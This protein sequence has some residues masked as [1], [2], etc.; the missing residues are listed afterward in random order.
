[1]A[2]NQKIL[3]LRKKH[4]FQGAEAEGLTRLSGKSRDVVKAMIAAGTIQYLDEHGE[5]LSIPVAELLHEI[6][7][8]SLCYTPANA[9]ILLALE[10]K[11]RHLGFQWHPTERTDRVRD[12]ESGEDKLI[13]RRF[14]NYTNFPL[15]AGTALTFAELLN[16]PIESFDGFRVRVAC[17]VITGADELAQMVETVAIMDATGMGYKG[18]SG[19]SWLPG[20][21]PM[22]LDARFFEQ[23]QLLA[24][25]VF[26]LFDVVVRRYE[27]DRQLN[28]ML[29]HRRPNKIL[30]LMMPGQAGIIRPDVVVVDN[31]DGTLRPVITELES[32]PAGQG[33]T[34]A[35]Q[36]GYGLPLSMVDTFVD[37]LGGRPFIVLGTHEWSEYVWEQA[38]FCRALRERGVDARMIFD[39][40]LSMIDA[41]V[42]IRWT[43]PN[44]L[45]PELRA[46]W[47][48]DFLTRLQELGFGDIVTGTSDLSSDVGN[49]VVFRFG[50]FDNFAPETL[51]RMAQWESQGAIVINPLQFPLE[52]KGLL[53]AIGLEGVKQ[54]ILGLPNGGAILDVLQRCV[55]ETRLV[56][57]DF[58]DI[59]ELER[60]QA[61]WLTKFGAW[62]GNN[63]SWGSRSLA[64]GTQLTRD[65]WRA[66]LRDVIA[67][68]H[69]VVAQ[70]VIASAAWRVGYSNGNGSSGV[71]ENARIR[72]TPFFLRRM[73]GQVV[74]CGSTATFRANTL[75][76][77]GASDAVEMPVIY[78]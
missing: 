72:L 51:Q 19:T 22:A 14:I 58:T 15:V 61:Y 76:I 66:N 30:P 27:T 4:G 65:Q 39:A 71:V 36:A 26:T 24:T 59:S 35:M 11:F 56:H 62:D 12:R 38:T 78:T 23:L 54:E 73:D 18:L 8:R 55:A 44:G 63:Q 64:V 77:H 21:Q 75:R 74:H 37:F 32:C 48:T 67:M 31:G 60:D 50:Y 5:N 6:T 68:P 16:Y 40:P 47:R 1:M 53:A 69:P 70:H 33:M 57:P 29:N 28:A 52:N 7:G 2:T 34:H 41:D 3:A 10:R 13:T 46:T 25:G 9:P 20:T 45:T 49:A 17:P 42:R 43:A